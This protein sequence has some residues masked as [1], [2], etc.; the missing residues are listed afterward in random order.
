M[1][2][3]HIEYSILNTHICYLFIFHFDFKY[4][5]NYTPILSI[6]LHFYETN[7][8]RVRHPSHSGRG[9]GSLTCHQFER[10]D[11]LMS[12]NFINIM[13]EYNIIHHHKRASFNHLILTCWY[14]NPHDIIISARMKPLNT[15]L[16][17]IG[18]NEEVIVVIDIPSDLR[19]LARSDAYICSQN[20]YGR[21]TWSCFH[22]SHDT[23]QGGRV[24]ECFLANSY[25]GIY[26]AFNIIT[27]LYAT[28][29]SYRPCY[30]EF[31]Y[32]INHR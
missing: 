21:N 15:F 17:H 14:L 30:R 12:A 28:S 6:F 26:P 32:L 16:S 31:I 9:H 7:F 1:Q 10:S 3:H 25:Y 8:T 29:Y 4:V 2:L 11:C 20:L 24:M 5:I 13:I 22:N 19:Y 27:L 23:A 18:I